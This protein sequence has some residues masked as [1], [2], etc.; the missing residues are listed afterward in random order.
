MLPTLGPK[1]KT[2][3]LAMGEKEKT[4][5]LKGYETVA[6]LGVGALRLS[7]LGKTWT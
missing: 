1:Q 4:W 2:R 6:R 3:L 5:I 7:G